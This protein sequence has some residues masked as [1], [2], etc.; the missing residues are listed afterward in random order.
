MIT[1]EWLDILLL[2]GRAGES[3]T[4]AKQTLE[5]ERDDEQQGKEARYAVRTAVGEAIT[6]VGEAW[7]ECC[8]RAGFKTTPPPS[9]A[10]GAP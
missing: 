8:V 5:R 1:G 10:D 4:A 7:I 2:I 6:E 9:A 3:L